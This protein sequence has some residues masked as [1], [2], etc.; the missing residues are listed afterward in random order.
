MR[1][2]QP[3]VCTVCLVSSR[4]L[5]ADTSSSG[6]CQC[7]GETGSPSMQ[8]LH[9]SVGHCNYCP[10]LHLLYMSIYCFS[11]LF[12]LFVL[13]DTTSGAAPASLTPQHYFIFF[14]FFFKQN[15]FAAPSCKQSKLGNSCTASTC[16]VSLPTLLHTHIHK[17]IHTQGLYVYPPFSQPPP[18]CPFLLILQFPVFS[19]LQSPGTSAGADVKRQ[20]QKMEGW[21]QGEMERERDSG[22]RP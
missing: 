13:S 5:T 21:R 7:T 14:F 6:Q 17:H 10:V 9:L 4:C 3:N 16:S 12:L 1:Q 8:Q 20:G 22:V 18:P 15:L 11:F 19:L 2:L